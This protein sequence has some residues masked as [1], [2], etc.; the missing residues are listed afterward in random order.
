MEACH[1]LLS[2]PQLYDNHVIYDGYANTYSLKHNG[3]SRTLAPLPTREPHKA[4]SSKGSKKIPH[5]S[6]GWEERTTSKSK[7]RI[8]ILMVNPNTSKGVEPLPL[9]AR[10]V[11][12]DEIPKEPPPRS[13]CPSK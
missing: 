9:I 10:Q 11:L 3:K 6:E 13:N 8:T 1:L 7:P 12:E 2:R 4:K 5:N